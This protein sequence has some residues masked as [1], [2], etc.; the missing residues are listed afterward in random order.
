M[1]VNPIYRAMLDKSISC[2]ISAIEL[3]NKPDFKYREDTFAILAINAWEL[4]LKS[5]LLKHNKYN[6]KSICQTEPL[7]TKKGDTHKTKTII[8]K[9]RSGNK[10]TLSLESVIENLNKKQ[11]IPEPI[12]NNIAILTELRDNAIHFI[13][14]DDISKQV[15]ELG[16]ACIKNYMTYIKEHSIEIDV[17]KY[18]LYLMPLA[19]IN[20][21]V[22]ADVEFRGEIKNF[23]SYS[24]K[25][26]IESTSSYDVLLSID[27]QFKKGNSLDAIKV[28]T[29]D[30]ADVTI[31][32]SE[33]D[34]LK[35]YPWNYKKVAYEAKKRYSDFKQNNTFN[36]AISE[37]KNQEK[38]AIERKL[39][40]D[41][42]NSNNKTYYYSTNVWN[43]LDKYFTKR[44]HP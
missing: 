20:E 33:E 12:I 27:V 15:Q 28:K 5:Q 37:I 43:I 3:Y 2:M 1:R 14:Y 19:Y 24:K 39:Y 8:S 30:N 32:L 17:N 40:P 44:H 13:N 29:S 31:S 42:P 25:L 18:N 16:F 36:K 23:L 4:I 34:I 35:K 41:N 6:F 7:K 9:N 21:K 10:K 22:I 38:L 11:K 26:K